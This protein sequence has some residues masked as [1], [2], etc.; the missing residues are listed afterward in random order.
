MVLKRSDIEAALEQIDIIEEHIHNRERWFGKS[1]DQSGDNWALEAGLTPYQA[2]S[3]NGAFGSDTNDEAKVIG[4]DDTPTISGKLTFD[5]HRIM[6]ESSSKATSWVLRIIYGLETMAAAEQAGQYT[7]VMVTEARKG[8]PI[9]V[10]MPRTT[11]DF[12]KVWV[13]AKN[14]SDN[15]TIE[16]FVGIH[17]YD[18]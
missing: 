15:A 11:C 18:E 4:T 5:F 1:S 6:V 12:C 2:I 14:A 17:E 10:I 16:F 7:D 3:G 13:R 9:E 8:S